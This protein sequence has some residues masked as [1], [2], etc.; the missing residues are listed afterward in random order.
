[1]VKAGGFKRFRRA[2][3][4]PFNIV[5]EEALD[6]ITEG[7]NTLLPLFQYY[8]TSNIALALKFSFSNL[9]HLSGQSFIIE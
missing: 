1:V 3:Q 6:S 8:I 4:T 5:Y 2:A 9:L 7:K